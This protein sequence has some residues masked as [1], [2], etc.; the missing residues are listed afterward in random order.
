MLRCQNYL[1]KCVDIS[2]EL[3]RG[4]GK[5]EKWRW[6]HLKILLKH[7]VP[8]YVTQAMQWL[9]FCLWH[10]IVSF[11]VISRWKGCGEIDVLVPSPIRNVFISP[12]FLL[13]HASDF[14]VLLCWLHST[15][16]Q[17]CFSLLRCLSFCSS[18]GAPFR[19]QSKASEASIGYSWVSQL[20]IPWFQG[21]GN[22]KCTS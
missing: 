4:V 9:F 5:L 10:Q 11:S 16:N 14:I 3:I 22:F 7:C 6:H 18:E 13:D 15:A 17:S 1:V 19:V 21:G 20:P 8:V 2:N 12:R